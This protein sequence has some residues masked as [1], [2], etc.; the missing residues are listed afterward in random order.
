[1]KKVTDPE[2]LALL[3]ADSSPVARPTGKK[4]TNPLILAQ[5]EGKEPTWQDRGRPMWDKAMAM[6]EAY[7]QTPL[8]KGSPV[9][10]LNT[11]NEAM[12][13]GFNRAG[14]ATAE[15][16]GRKQVN[17]LLAAAAGTAV[18][19]APDVALSMSPQKINSGLNAARGFAQRGLGATMAQLKTPFARGQAAKAA[20]VA[21]EKNVIPWTGSPQV[22]FDKASELAS[23]SGK[24]IGEVL[25]KVSF[26]Q[27]APDA[28]RDLELFRREIT[29]GTDKG[30]FASANGVIDNIKSTILEL[31]GR[32]ASAKEYNQAKNILGNSMNYLTDASSQAVN[33]KTV[34]TMAKTIRDT[35]RKLVPGSYLEFVENQRLFNAAESMK[36]F[37]NPELARQAGNN[38][39]T[40]TGTIVAA[41]QAASGNLGKAVAELGLIE[42]L[43]RR[44]R[45]ATAKQLYDF[46]KSRVSAA[47]NALLAISRKI[48]NDRGQKDGE[49]KR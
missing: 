15:A 24:K 17:P 8:Y 47:P 39:I 49:S 21:L 1:M 26:E 18:S 13:S 6:R 12:M 3:E 30:L 27:I 45:L 40:P 23:K 9:G 37:L 28:E 29:K 16:L 4:V 41:T 31:Y 25:N 48:T 43:K 46:S 11:A 44:G 35:V 20:E 33:K 36:K 10:M 19:M 42:A 32:G 14:E 7:K 2:L 34:N 5:L 38:I 22:A